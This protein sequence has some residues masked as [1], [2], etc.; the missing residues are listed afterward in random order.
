VS[1]LLAGLPDIESWLT[2][3][4]MAQSWQALA[5]QAIKNSE[6]VLIYETPIPHRS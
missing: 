5:E 4:G 2:L 1:I 6:T 3:L